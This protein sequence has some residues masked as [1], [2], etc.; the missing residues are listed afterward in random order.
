MKILDFGLAKLVKQQPE[1]VSNVPTADARGH[2]ARHG[3]LHVARAGERQAARFPVG[4]VLARLD[5]LRDGDGRPRLPARNE[6]RDAHRDHSRGRRADRTAKRVGPGAVSLDRGPV[7]PEGSRGALRVDARSRARHQEH[8]RA[9]V[10]GLGVGRDRPPEI[11]GIARAPRRRPILR[12]ALSAAP[13][14]RRSPRGC[15]S[16]SVSPPRRRPPISRSRSAAARSAP[17]GSRPTDRRSSTARPGTGRRSSS[18]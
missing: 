16:R 7:S 11:A 6:R 10:R 18:S 3:R 8:P 4:P 14:S 9:S 5:P 15:S 1:E 17:R 12:A 13:F 2:G